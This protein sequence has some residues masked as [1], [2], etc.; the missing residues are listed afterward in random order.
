M[1]Y[2]GERMVPD[3]ADAGTFWEH[4]LRYRFAAR[5]VQ[6]CRVLDIACGEGYGSASLL[7]AGAE[8]VIGVDVS[9]EACA[10]ARARYGLDAREGSAEAI[11][12]PDASV[13]VIVSFETIEHLTT[14]DLF[15][16]EC[17]RVLRPGGQLI[18]STPNVPVYH[19]RAPNN[20]Y[21]L[22]ELTLDEFR[23][24]LEPGFQDLALY[25]QCVPPSHW[26]QRRGIRRLVSLWHRVAAPHMYL[27]PTTAERD[28][29]VQLITRPSHWRDRFDP[30]RVR[31][32]PAAKL[33]TAVYLIAT[34]IRKH[35]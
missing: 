29:V 25:G 5:R 32:M 14:P 17:R 23:T 28:G 35:D 8:S 21:H 3:A 33:E 24:A 19:I 7:A 6:N 2:T 9:P 18:I 10:H 30:Y 22:R 1:E 11:P 31:S 13:D 12:L 15:V 16:K 20:P 27:P 4:V 34:A 26:Q